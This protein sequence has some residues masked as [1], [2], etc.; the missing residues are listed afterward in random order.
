MTGVKRNIQAKLL[1]LL[2]EFP[3]VVLLGA[4]QV[5]KTTL[6]KTTCPDWK[7]IDLENYADLELLQADPNFFFEQNPNR[8]II[9]EGQEYPEVFKVLRG[10]IDADRKAKGRFIITGSSN[11]ELLKH[12]SESLAGRVAIINVSPLK[13]NEYYKLPL[14]NFYKLFTNDL[15]IEYFINK[16]PSLTNNQMQYIWLK[17]GYPEPTLQN[18]IGF[19]KRWM[20]N[21]L[22]T[23]V[24][25]DIAKLFPKLN[26]MVYQ[27]FIRM[28][29][30]LSAT[31]LNQKNFARSLEVSAP[32]IK[33]YLTIA[34]G[35]YIWR[36]LYSFESKVTTSVTKMP[37][38]YLRDTGLMHFMLKI[39]DFDNLFH[40]PI[41]G[42]SFESF[43]IE[44]IIK[45]IE[46][47]LITNLQ[48][49]YYRTKNG[50]EIDLILEGDF[51]ILPIE[52]KQGTRVRIDKL[53]ALKDFIIKHKLP[54]GL[55]IN[56]SSEAKWLTKEILQLPIGWL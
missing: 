47:S 37:K 7:Y 3:V 44:E 48:P 20:E 46:S 42:G 53:T 54:F 9:D 51:G 10:V 55:V 24:H 5:G 31:I 45:G 43:V 8:L 49:Y 2:E 11:P 40:D 13:A 50:A 41:S 28:L 35:T 26:K 32:M 39:T 25:R 21:Y 52:I 15:S 17:G 1:K 36:N 56:Q 19:Y 29:G 38:G 23:Y 34:D 14:S 22:Q 33:N 27:R 16:T 30:K 18:D 4:S 6:A 12:I